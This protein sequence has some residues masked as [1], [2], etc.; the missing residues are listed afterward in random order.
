M[1]TKVLQNLQIL[2]VNKMSKYTK[3]PFCRWRRKVPESFA[4]VLVIYQRCF[5]HLHGE[6]SL[7]ITYEE[8]VV[9]LVEIF[10]MLYGE[11]NSN[12]LFPGARRSQENSVHIMKTI[13]FN[14]QFSVPA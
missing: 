11:R 8:I 4:K 12:T 10:P 3:I 5:K 1:L 9:Q 7:T 2:T 13:F 14:I 6:E